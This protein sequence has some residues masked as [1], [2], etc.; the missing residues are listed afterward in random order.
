MKIINISEKEFE[1]L[2]D[3]A[4]STNTKEPEFNIKNYIERHKE[5]VRSR[6]RMLIKKGVIKKKNCEVCNSKKS[7][8]HH[9][10]YEDIFKIRWVCPKHHHSKR[11]P[12]R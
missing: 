5:K 8:A 10:D 3:H 12:D 9:E 4:K 2:E 6:T 11:G 7:Q 1:F